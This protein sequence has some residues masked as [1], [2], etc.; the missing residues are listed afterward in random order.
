MKKQLKLITLLILV[1][2]LLVIFSNSTFRMPGNQQNYEPIQPI[3]FSHR[4]HAGEME[5]PCQYCHCGA[6]QSRHAGIPATSVCMNCHKYVSATKDDLRLEEEQAMAEGRE[7]R[8][9]TSLEIIKI[10]SAMGYDPQGNP[11]E[12]K[13]GKSV[14]WVKVHNIP[15]FVFFSH[16]PHIAAG[17]DCTDC[18]GDVA[19]MER[20]K[21]TEDLSMGWCLDCHR[22]DH[23]SL[24]AAP[25]RTQLLLDCATCHY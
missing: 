23:E 20:I 6:S 15:D 19:S 5:V 18:H 24:T 21:Q 11:V 8:P 4:L 7:M 16:K 13:A 12:G 9:L 1:G 10:Y 2:G 17:V 3:D 22:K 14:E 25:E